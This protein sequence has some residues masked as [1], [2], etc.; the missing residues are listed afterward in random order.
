MKRYFTAK[1]DSSSEVVPKNFNV[2]EVDILKFY[3]RNFKGELAKK[4]AF[5]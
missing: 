5:S 3:Y 2:T 1:Q 4:R